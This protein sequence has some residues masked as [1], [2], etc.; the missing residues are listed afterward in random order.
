MFTGGSKLIE[1]VW[2]YRSDGMVILGLVLSEWVQNIGWN[3]FEVDTTLKKD[4]GKKQTSN[5]VLS[6]SEFRFQSS[7]FLLSF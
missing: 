3:H 5:L 6:T 4:E 1:K 7:L 2:W